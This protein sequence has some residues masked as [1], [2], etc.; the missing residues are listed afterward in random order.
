MPA[1]TERITMTRRRRPW[2]IAGAARALTPMTAALPATA[3]SAVLAR[4]S[5]ELAL[6]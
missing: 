5:Q 2:I 6:Y 1:I 4:L 3:T